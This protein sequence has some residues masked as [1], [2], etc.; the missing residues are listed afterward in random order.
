MR[1]DG[2]RVPV[3]VRARFIYRNGEPV[4]VQGIARDISE[5]RQAELVLRQSE[6]RF[7][8]LVQNIS[9]VITVIGVDSKILYISPSIER[10]LGYI[11]PSCRARLVS[12]LCIRAT[13][14]WPKTGLPRHSPATADIGVPVAPQEWFMDLCR[15]HGR[16]PAR[17]SSGRRFCHEHPRR[18]RAQL[19]EQTLK[20]SEERYIELFENASDILFTLDLDGNFTS[21]NKAA[22]QIFGYSR[23]EAM[24]AN[25]ALMMRR[26]SYEEAS[27]RQQ[28]IA[29]GKIRPLEVELFA[30]DGRKV[31]L[32][33]TM[34]VIYHDGEP[35]EVC[36]D[37]PRRDRAEAARGAARIPCEAR[38]A[39]RAAEPD[40]G[41]R[42]A[43]H[44]HRQGTP[45]S[46]QRPPL[47]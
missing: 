41:R 24:G 7:R 47:S 22:E 6:E 39:H 28:Q 43:D 17:Q 3:E 38:R 36:R 30:R 42:T 18:Q 46:K 26:G 33:I 40:S 29:D 45:R 27:Q 1:K 10:L 23:E 20:A 5:R 44:C 4:A 15:G 11:R 14:R 35:F 37:C 19:A 13:G 31:A 16:Q 32:E 9:D 34:R 21:I 25:A 2:S 8:S 12:T